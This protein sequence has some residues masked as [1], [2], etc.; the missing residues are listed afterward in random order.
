M[1]W[2]APRRLVAGSVLRGRRDLDAEGREHW[3]RTITAAEL[4]EVLERHAAWL[5]SAGKEGERAGLS[6]ADLRKAV[7]GGAD[8]RKASLQH[9]ALD[10]AD[11]SLAQ[12]EGAHL[13]SANLSGA[14]LA[15]A[16]LRKA[17][18]QDVDLTDANLYAADVSSANLWDADLRRAEVGQ[19]KFNRNTWVQGLLV[20]ADSLAAAPLFKRHVE[21][22]RF[23][24]SFEEEHPRLAW[25]WR[26]SSDY[27][28][29]WTRWASWSA[30]CAVAFGFAFSYAPAWFPTW[31]PTPFRFEQA[32]STGFSPLYFSIVTFTTLGFGDYTPAN[33]WA[34]LAVVAEVV[35]GYIMLGGL[36]AILASRLARR[37]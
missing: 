36:V 9:A 3:L 11:L 8:L 20:D 29:S 12:L 4:A 19:L 31:W 26:I 27:G 7:L 32:Y 13:T 25:L 15:A 23:I 16:N 10:S 28:R 30:V 18:L 35:L 33:L 34:E 6:R 24:W 21:D 1:A 17:S 5:S 14:D 37:S 22:W 2:F